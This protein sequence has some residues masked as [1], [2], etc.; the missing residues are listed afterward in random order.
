MGR[1]LWVG[2]DVL[3]LTSSPSPLAKAGHTTLTYCKDVGKCSLSQVD[4]EASQPGAQPSASIQPFPYR[5][6]LVC[7]RADENYYIP[8]TSKAQSKVLVVG[9]GSCFPSFLIMDC[10][11]WVTNSAILLVA[12]SCVLSEE[13]PVACSGGSDSLFP[14]SIS[15]HCSEVTSQDKYCP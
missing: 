7:V 15:P 5:S 11:S 4:Q 1:G 10:Q 3:F 12:H 6:S 8:P 14:F 2:Q 13:G 9:G